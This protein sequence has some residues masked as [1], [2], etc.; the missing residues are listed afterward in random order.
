MFKKEKYIRQR[1]DI[2]MD[3]KNIYCVQIVYFYTF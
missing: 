2:I 1:S 3:F